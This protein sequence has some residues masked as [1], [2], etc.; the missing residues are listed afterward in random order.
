MPGNK[1]GTETSRFHHQ[2]HLATDVDGNENGKKA[3]GLYKQNDNYRIYSI[4]RPGRLLL[5]WTLRVG[6]Y[7][8]WALI[9]GG[10]LFE[11]GRL[12]K[13]SP[14][15]ESVVCLFCDKTINGHNAVKM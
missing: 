7:S 12:I 9:R 11:A 8:R 2:S 1:T 3:N 4:N 10:R 15:S 13:L 6:A 14:F 5:F